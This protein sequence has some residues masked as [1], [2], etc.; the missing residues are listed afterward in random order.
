VLAK[1]EG[2]KGKTGARKYIG[3][4]GVHLPPTQACLGDEARGMGSEREAES[5]NAHGLA[6]ENKPLLRRRDTLLLLELLL[7]LLSLC[8]IAFVR[9][10]THSRLSRSTYEE[11]RKTRGTHGVGSLDVELDLLRHSTVR[12]EGQVR[13]EEERTEEGFGVRER[14]REE[15]S[16]VSTSF[17]SF[18]DQGR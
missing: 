2:R 10:S 3:V 6:E 12:T 7:D 17:S 16:E 18:R 5:E 11:E 13:K 15:W 14:G 4:S 8:A 9:K 1:R